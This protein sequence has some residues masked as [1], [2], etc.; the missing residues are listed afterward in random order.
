MKASRF[1]EE[2]IIHL[3]QRAERDEKS[4]TTPVDAVR[5]RVGANEEPHMMPKRLVA[6]GP[7]VTHP[8]H[9]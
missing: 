3:L 7:L 5:V 6:L 2:W 8:S 9:C 4:N 1:S